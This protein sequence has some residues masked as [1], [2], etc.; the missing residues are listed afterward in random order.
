MNVEDEA[1]GSELGCGESALGRHLRDVA[2]PQR[3]GGS[4]GKSPKLAQPQFPPCQLWIVPPPSNTSRD[5]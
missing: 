2:S 5:H 1:L 4:L 3:R